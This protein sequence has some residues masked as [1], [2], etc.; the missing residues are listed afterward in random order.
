ME[1]K[2]GRNFYFRSINV[3][4]RFFARG[5]DAKL[6]PA[7]LTLAERGSVIDGPVGPKVAPPSMF[8]GD[9]FIEV[10]YPTEDAG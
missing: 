9:N 8:H 2:S 5:R 3:S 10:R 7:E 6:L 1:P 4:W